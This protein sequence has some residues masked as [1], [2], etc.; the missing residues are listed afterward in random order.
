MC[1]MEVAETR[2]RKG[3][4]PPSS[5]IP[6]HT[7]GYDFNVAPNGK[8]NTRKPATVFCSEAKRPDL[9]PNTAA[10]ESNH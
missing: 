2:R 1:A 10:S 4:R 5:N 6:G 8:Q 3:L 7:S 9:A